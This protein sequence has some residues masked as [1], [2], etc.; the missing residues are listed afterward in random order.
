MTRSFR[1][2]AT[3]LCLVVLPP[4]AASCSKDSDPLE[5]SL[6]GPSESGVMVRT[7]V[8]RESSH[9]WVEAWIDIFIMNAT[10]TTFVQTTSS[11]C[12]IGFDILDSGNRVIGPYEECYDA[13]GEIRLDPGESIQRRLAWD[14]KVVI[15][16]QE[17]DYLPDGTYLIAGGIQWGEVVVLGDT[18][19]FE[20]ER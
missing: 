13:V 5:P 12:D 10:D 18:V 3:L 6:G 7:E 11:S 14:G 15:G 2:L 4:A 8:T 16:T 9:E 1:G 20:W 17:Y 19:A